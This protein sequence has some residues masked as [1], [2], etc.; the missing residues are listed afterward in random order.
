MGDLSGLDPLLLAHDSGRMDSLK[1]FLVRA[2]RSGAFIGRPEHARYDLSKTADCTWCGLPDTNLH[3]L[4][5]P[6]FAAVRAELER[7]RP[8]LLPSRFSLESCFDGDPAHHQTF[9]S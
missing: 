4:E 2:L 3:W 1:A 6:G 7:L 8:H 5:C 9:V